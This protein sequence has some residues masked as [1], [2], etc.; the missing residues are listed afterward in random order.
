MTHHIENDETGE[1]VYTPTSAEDCDRWFDENDPGY[2]DHT[3]IEITNAT[4]E[5]VR[6]AFANTRGA[7]A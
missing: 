6:A 4:H 1:I 3:H 7:F 5:A 2:R